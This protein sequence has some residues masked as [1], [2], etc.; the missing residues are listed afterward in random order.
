MDGI[1]DCAV[2]LVNLR[3]L[4]LVKDLISKSPKVSSRLNSKID[5]QINQVEQKI[6]SN[7]KKCKVTSEKSDN[8]IKKSVLKQ[9]T[10]EYCR[11]SFYLEYLKEEYDKVSVLTSSGTS[12]T[13]GGASTTDGG[14]SIPIGQIIKS[15]GQSMSEIDQ[16]AIDIVKAYPITFKSYSEYE[17]N[18]AVHIL[19]ELLREEFLV[20]REE[21]HKVLNPM[22][23]VV[24][25]I[26]NA[27]KK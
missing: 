16:E 4:K 15:F 24:Y 20:L 1:Y 14:A 19:L 8:I 2:S 12:T 18:L 3:A 10:Y 25:K 22:N 17:N 13:D 9:T 11:Y 23:Q 26:A 6:S 21:L 5:Q 27:M 7:Q